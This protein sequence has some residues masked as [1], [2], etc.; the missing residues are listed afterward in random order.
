MEPFTQSLCLLII[1]ALSLC[2]ATEYYV[3]PS[4]P[5]NTS[6]PAQPCL[7]LNEYASHSEH[8]FTS[9]NIEFRFLPGTHLLNISISVRNVHNVSFTSLET[10][11]SPQIVFYKQNQCNNVSHDQ[12]DAVKCTP[13]G[14]WNATA[15]TIT[16]LGVLV[17]PQNK[18]VDYFSS[19]V[20]G[21]GF[22]NVTQLHLHHCN[23]LLKIKLKTQITF[24][25]IVY[26]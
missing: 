2:G 19:S 11:K 13:F 20:L 17:Y 9:S 14:F 4:E 7:T 8:Y 23:I 21:I 5:T 24:F 12:M 1:S 22:T 25:L 26:T 10:E 18:P 15:I 16:R 3:R 6:C